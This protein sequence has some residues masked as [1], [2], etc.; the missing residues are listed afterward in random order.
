MR[1]E[2]ILAMAL[3]AVVAGCSDSPP[4]NLTTDAGD[5]D[6]TTG[7]DADTDTDTDTET[8]TGTD[9]DTDPPGPDERPPTTLFQT[10]E[11]VLP[12]EDQTGL[13]GGGDRSEWGITVTGAGEARVALDDLGVGEAPETPI[14]EPSSLM[15][16]WHVTDAQ[17]ADEESPSRLINGDAFSESAYRWQESWGSQ[18]LD[19]SIRTANDLAYFRPFDLALLTG[20]MIDNIHANELD[21]FIGTMDGE[22]VDPDSGDDDDPIPGSLNDPHDAFQ[23]E[24]LTTDVPWYSVAGNHDLLELGNGSLLSWMLADSTGTTTSTL[25]KAVVPT[26]LD[27]PYYSDESAVPERCY[28][29]PKSAFTSSTVVAD[30]ERALIDGY[31]WMDGHMGTYTVPDGHGYTS[32]SLQEEFGSY[33]I[34]DIVPGIPSAIIVL[35]MVSSSGQWGTF[36][37]DIELWLEARLQEAQAADRVVIVASHHTARSIDDDEQSEAFIALLNEY[38]NVVAHIGGHTHDNR[39]TPRPAPDGY[40]PEHGYWEI[41]TSA[42]IDWPQQTRLIEVVDNRDGTGDIL[43][44]MLDYQIPDELQLVEGGR[45]YALWDVHSGG[46]D[47]GSGDPEDRNVALRIAWPDALADALALLPD[48]EVE[49]DNYAVDE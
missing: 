43:C 1:T 22:V 7:T 40:G 35:D 37:S 38:P 11:S 42:I 30:P 33:V 6:T 2:W 8:D 24:G 19:A 5:T 44:T 49:A 47:T 45:F 23:A 16:I 14:G 3:A 28:L 29:P 25:S 34:E 39:I 18:F 31:G 48:R 9:T 36:S 26:C 12:E 46:G 32:E 15:Y 13:L 41:E 21:W 10:V 27:T 20:D 17:I 4:D